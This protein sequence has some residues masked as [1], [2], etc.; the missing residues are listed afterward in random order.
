MTTLVTVALVIAGLKAGVP[1]AEPMTY[2]FVSDTDR[3]VGVVWWADDVHL[4]GKINKS[5]DFVHEIKNIH[6]S[7][8]LGIPP[9]SVINGGPKRKAFE[10]RSGVLIPGEIQDDGR[11]VPEVGGKI[12]KFADYTYSLTAPRIWNLPGYFVPN[13]PK[14]AEKK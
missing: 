1:S 7:W 12:I 10:F 6:K 5:G 14:A 11:F 9:H 8:S 13:E 2:K 4:I 3:L